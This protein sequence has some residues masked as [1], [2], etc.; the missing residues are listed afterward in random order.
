M[1]L[2]DTTKKKADITLWGYL[3]KNQLKVIYIF[4]GISYVS[5]GRKYVTVAKD[6]NFLII[7]NTIVLNAKFMY[8]LCS[9]Y[10][11]ERDWKH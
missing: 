4:I 2:I 6:E 3:I 5:I 9:M 11:N 8:C 1:H 7:W 10:D